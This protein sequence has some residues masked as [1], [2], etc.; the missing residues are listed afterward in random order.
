MKQLNN[1][2]EDT[3]TQLLTSLRV[4]SS[5]YCL[6]ELRDPW[7]FRVEGRNV[8]KFHLILEGSAWLCIDD[9]E[10]LRMETGDMVILPHGHAHSMKDRPD[11]RV[12][13]LDRILIDHPVDDG[14]RMYYG[15]RG[16]LTRIL[17]GGFSLNET[18]PEPILAMLPNIVHVDARG[19]RVS[20]W[21]DATFQMLREEASQTLPGAKAVFAKIADVFL[22]QALRT[23]LAGTADAGL[24]P[25]EA[26][27]DPAIAQA[28]HLIH[29]E[30][31]HD[32]SVGQLAYQ[33]GMS[34]SGFSDR[35]RQLTG[36]S[37]MRYTTKVRLTRAAGYL[38]T[39]DRS[40]SSIARECGY[41]S[42]A[43][44]SKAFKREFGMTPGEYRQTASRRPMLK[45]A[46]S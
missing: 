36:E 20:P 45:V 44:L 30:P 23:F 11:S 37:P 43:S 40:Q 41:N 31:S 15:G 22:T 17:C 25:L 18:A 21:I 6:S 7:G 9:V 33:V 14:G 29:T 38:A 4:H 24:Y 39:T 42:D 2:S 1:H 16:D 8:A 26:M 3:L 46:A 12:E 27:N 5:I 34:R 32:W 13:T 35:F 10:P 28:V 19:E